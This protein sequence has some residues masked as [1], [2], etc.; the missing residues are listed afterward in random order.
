MLFFFFSNR[1]KNCEAI[2]SEIGVWKT[3]RD[4]KVKQV[5]EESFITSDI[6]L[7]RTEQKTE[8]NNK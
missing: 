5:W 3:K 4:T 1:W 2:V 7:G 8:M 6:L